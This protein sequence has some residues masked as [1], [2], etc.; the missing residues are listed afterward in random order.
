[1]I[2]PEDFVA[3]LAEHGVSRYAGVPDS[4]L[5]PLIES[6]EA[7]TSTDHVVAA[8]EGGAV[9]YAIGAFL[10]S[11]RLCAVYMQNSGL[12]NA[13]N[14]LIA[15]AHEKVYG[16]PMVLIIGWRGEP[17][18][19]DEPQH[20]VQGQVTKSLLDSLDI[21]SIILETDSS[22]ARPQ[23]HGF[24]R[25]ASTASRPMAI[26]VRN[27]TFTRP[28]DSIELKGGSSLSREEALEAVAQQIPNNSRVVATTGMLGR[29]LWELRERASASH[30]NDFLAVGGMGHAS[31]IALGIAEANPNMTVWCLDGDGAILMHLGSLAV[32]GQRKPAN[33]RH[34][35][36]NNFAHDS[37]GGQ[38]TAMRSVD[39]KKL[40][41]G[42]G[43]TW[44]GSATT[45]A[46]TSKLAAE[47]AAGNG[48][49]LV[50]V[51]IRTGARSN[52]GRPSPTIFAPRA[53]FLDEKEHD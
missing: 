11:G 21:P 25:E 39:T 22:K 42:L 36:F 52:L 4:L 6:L 3:W 15:L 16:I 51:R 40:I 12:G 32:I 47:L 24:L 2:A 29:E 14:P 5:S 18:R 28:G 10:E 19:D 53:Q 9:G 45:S 33:L 44:L 30:Q 50:E 20:L 37:V 26:L 46:E 1:M 23:I 17:G 27:K 48:P 7:S 41:Q 31:S 34:V 35:V 43:Y 38:T 13:V 8:N 49:G